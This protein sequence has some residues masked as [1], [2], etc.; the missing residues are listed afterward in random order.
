MAKLDETSVTAI[1]M[2]FLV[3]NLSR[4]LRQILSVFFCLFLTV[5]SRESRQININYI[6]M[7][8]K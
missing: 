1:A 2:T 4:L 3:M 5:G 6:G 7:E 8:E